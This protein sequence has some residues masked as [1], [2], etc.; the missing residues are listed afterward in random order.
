MLTIEKLLKL[1]DNEISNTVD[2]LLKKNNNKRDEF[3]IEFE[4]VEKDYR[5]LKKKELD[6][7]PDKLGELEI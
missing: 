6:K 2:E 5:K 7:F 1:N 3:K 4:N